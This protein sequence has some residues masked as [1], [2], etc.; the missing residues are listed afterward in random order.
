MPSSIAAR[1]SPINC[2]AAIPMMK[3]DI[4]E[5]EDHQQQPATSAVSKTDVPRGPEEIDALQ[6][7]DEQ[8]RIAERRERATDIGD[9]KNEEN[10][11]VHVVKPR[12]R[13]RATADGSGSLQRRWCRR[14]SP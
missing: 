6:E 11:H 3:P 1:T 12:S 9:E 7:S 2:D 5:T 4:D 10:D 14:N 8:R 13:W